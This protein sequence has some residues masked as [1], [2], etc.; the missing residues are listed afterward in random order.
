MRRDA[1][2][3]SGS[4]RRPQPGTHELRVEVTPPWP[5]RLPRGSGMDGVMRCRDGVVQRLLHHGD[6]PVVVRVAQTAPDRVLFGAQASSEAAA[7]WGIERMRF[8]LGVDDD[9]RE[10]HDRFRDDPLIGAAV[11]SKPTV[12]LRRRPVAFEALAWAITEQL[13]E[14]VR[15]A[16]IQRR[17]VWK[18]GRQHAASGLR[19]LPSA[20][21]VAAQAPA[22]L[23]SFDLADKRALALRRAAHEVASGR[24]DLDDPDHERGWRRLDAIPEIGSWTLE[25]T[26]LLGQGRMDQLPA[27]DLAYRKLVGRLLT[28]DPRAR[29][30]EEDVRSFFA[31][32]GAWAGLAGAYALRAAAPELKAVAAAA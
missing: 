32:Y 8:A 18:L 14:Y 17:I 21:T 24:V 27:G 7:A 28:G 12:R 23:C 6:D 5:F 22:L 1:R 11:R 31:P 9:L 26:A 19:D 3:A 25:V 10:F 15:A 29:V 2:V 13:I 4:W 30:D 16:A 20:A